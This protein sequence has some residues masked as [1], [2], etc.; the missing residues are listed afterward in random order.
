MP[1]IEITS[2]QNESGDVE[3]TFSYGEFDLGNWKGK[4]DDIEKVLSVYNICGVIPLSFPTLTLLIDYAYKA[5]CGL[6]ESGFSLSWFDESLRGRMIRGA[7]HV[8]RQMGESTPREFRDFAQ[9]LMTEESVAEQV[10]MMTIRTQ[11]E[12][13]EE[14]VPF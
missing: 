12:D 11:L 3:Y 4:A 9:S 10:R 13:V 2:T 8:L 14:E 6:C 5:H 1:L 7:E